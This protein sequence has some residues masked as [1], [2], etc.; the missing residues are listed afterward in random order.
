MQ[1]FKRGI[2]NLPIY[3]DGVLEVFEM[4]QTKD[5]CPMEYIKSTGKKLYFEELSVTDRLR[6]EAEQR[7]KNISLKV[8]IPQTKEITSMNVVKIGSE[9]HKVFNSYHF[10]NKE[11]FKQ[12]DLTLE[13]YP[14]PRL[15]ED[16]GKR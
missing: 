14:N 5:T 11:G 9:Y 13:N 2:T 4:K 8:R 12:T 10:T 3:N 7:D 1:N 15:E 16:C 6:F